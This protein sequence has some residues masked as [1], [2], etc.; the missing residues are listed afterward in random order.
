MVMTSLWSYEHAPFFSSSVHH[1]FHSTVDPAEVRK[2]QLL[3]NKWW[4]IQGEFAPLH[5]MNALRVPF[6][7]SVYKFRTTILVKR[8]MCHSL[9]HYK[10]Q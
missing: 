3:A 6:I 2:F 7:R 1:F 9:T 4:D 5:A 10:W 8:I